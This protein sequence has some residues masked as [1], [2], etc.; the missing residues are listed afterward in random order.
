ML[1]LS[2][3]VAVLLSLL[4]LSI[5]EVSRAGEKETAA[6]PRLVRAKDPKLDRE[7]DYLICDLGK[8]VELKLVKVAAKGKTFT[9]GSPKEEKGHQKGE[10]QQDITFTDDYYL[11]VHEVTQKQFRA[12]MGYNLSYFSRNAKGKAGVDYGSWQPGGGKD[13]IP[14]GEDTEDYP[15]ENGRRRLGRGLHNG[16]FLMALRRAAREQRR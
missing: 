3:S 16:R 8:G 15:V 4:C 10:E 11:G 9:I 1:R 7:F 14:A 5:P 12:V 13:R 6:N 2:S